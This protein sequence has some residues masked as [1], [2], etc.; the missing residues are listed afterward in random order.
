VRP[1]RHGSAAAYPHRQMGTEGVEQVVEVP[2]LY[3]HDLGSSGR[4]RSARPVGAV[5]GRHTG[6]QQKC[7]AM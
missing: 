6:G 3:A 5:S 7:G 4:P 2:L 1:A